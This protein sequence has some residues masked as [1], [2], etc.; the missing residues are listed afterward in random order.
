[1]C[2]ACTFVLL[3]SSNAVIFQFHTAFECF[4]FKLPQA[5]ANVERAIIK[6]L[7]KQYNDILTP[8]KDSVPKKLGM[9][10][11]KLARR[12]STALY[13]VPAQVS[14]THSNHLIS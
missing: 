13:S 14:A 7:Q 9:Q 3:K 11:Q 1:M 8:L 10:V 5:V 4:L 2:H 6:A 12:Q